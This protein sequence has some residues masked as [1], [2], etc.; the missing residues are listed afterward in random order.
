[1]KLTI[2][3]KS[4]RFIKGLNHFLECKTANLPLILVTYHLH[5]RWLEEIPQD[6]LELIV[7]LFLSSLLVFMLDVLSDHLLIQSD[8]TH[9]LTAGQ[10]VFS[11][12]TFLHAL[13]LAMDLNC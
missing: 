12:K 11:G 8:R 13:Q 1:M 10:K 4:K 3:V 6:G 7:D 5:S 2:L 9:T